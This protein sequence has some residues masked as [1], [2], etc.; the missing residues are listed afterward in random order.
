[1]HIF[2]MNVIKTNLLSFVRFK[3]STSVFNGRM[4]FFFFL[5]ICSYFLKSKGGR[6]VC[7]G[8]LPFMGEKFLEISLQ[9]FIDLK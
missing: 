8:N 9:S 2:V 5:Y 6:N 1:M 4:E 3:L 7:N